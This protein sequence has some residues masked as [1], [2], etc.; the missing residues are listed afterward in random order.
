MK[1]SATR[2]L[3]AIVLLAGFIVLNNLSAAPPV[4]SNIRATQRPGTQVVDILYNLSAVGPCSITVA[5]SA[6]GTNYTV[7]VF[8]LTGA[9][10]SGVSP[11]LDRA[12]VWNAGQDWPGNFTDKCRVRVTADDGTS[13]TPPPAM[14]II[15]A[16]SFNMGDN[17]AESGDAFP[18]HPVFI[19][20]FYMDKF[21]VTSALWDDVYFWA[22][23]QCP[24]SG[25]LRIACEQNRLANRHSQCVD[26]FRKPSRH[27]E[28]LARFASAGAGC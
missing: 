2:I 5:V 10:G 6:N 8:T 17:Y 25:H 26:N 1:T 20:G 12:I 18:V 23:G 15:P 22:I 9:V 21:E 16:G 14:V 4:V 27:A 24:H 3:P 28:F 7:P 13:P 11:G 19:S